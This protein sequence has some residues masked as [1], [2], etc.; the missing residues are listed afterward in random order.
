VEWLVARQPLVVLERREQ[1]E[2]G[3]RAVGVRDP[4]NPRALASSGMNVARSRASRSASSQ[5]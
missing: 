3:V 1:L 5:S 4:S 2:A